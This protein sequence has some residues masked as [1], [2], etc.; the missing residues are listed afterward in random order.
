M[1][2]I[3]KINTLGVVKVRDHGV[4][5]DGGELGEILLPL[6]YVPEGCAVGDELAVFVYA[7]SDDTLVAT[8]QRPRAMAGQFAYLKVVAVG[9]Y[10]AF[11]DWGLMKDLLVPFSEQIGKMEE[12]RSY[13]VRV[14]LDEATERLAA[15][16]KID[17]FLDRYP[18]RYRHG[19]AVDLL[20]AGQTDLGY[21]AIVDNAHWGVLYEAEVFKPLRYGQRVKGYIKRVREDGKID[22]SLQQPGYARIDGVAADILARLR[23]EGGFIP[24]HD[25]SPPEDIYAMFGVSKKAFKLGISALY[26]ER[27]IR[28]EKDGLHLGD[29]G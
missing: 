8:T 2:E 6:R 5:L 13:I 15:S 28:I 1:T 11:L 29:E 22:L 4:Y 14:F 26:R 3:G 12:G 23:R 16:Q 27:L 19:Q 24:L 21:K 17:K 20:I 9:Q 18:P 7:D 10:G 25:K